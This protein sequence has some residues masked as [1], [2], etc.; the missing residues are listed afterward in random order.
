MNPKECYTRAPF[1]F[2]R[3]KVAISFLEIYDKVSYG[4]P[5]FPPF[6]LYNKVSLCFKNIVCV[7]P[8]CKETVEN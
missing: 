1:A 2:S 5:I 7:F 4:Q 3:V 6:C 8:N